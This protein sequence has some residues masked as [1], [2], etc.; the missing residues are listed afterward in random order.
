MKR[1]LP[2]I[3]IHGTDF[4]IDV[5]SLSLKERANE[6]NFIPFGY[7]ADVPGGYEFEYGLD[8]RN[9]HTIWTD[10]ESVRIKIPELVELDPFGMSQRYQVSMEQLKGKTDFEIMVD[11]QAFDLRVNKGVLPT[12]D[13]AGDL[14]YVVLDKDRLIPKDDPQ[15]VGIPMPSFIQYDQVLGEN[16][17]A[18]D[19]KKREIKEL[20]YLKITEIPKN[21]IAV[22]LPYSF[23]LDPVGWNWQ[24]NRDAKTAL[25]TSN[26]SMHFSSPKIP[27]EKTDLPDIIKE[28]LEELRQKKVEKIKSGLTKPLVNKR[29]R[30]RRI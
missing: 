1:E 20:D 24:N 15:S 12:I 10:E 7:M 27:W 30:G 29:N 17:F 18:Y 21:L 16:V 26:L 14:F 2:I 4:F 6:N 23:S 19:P 11:Q 3:N 28:N 13:I 8:S 9:I 5:E 22:R 25:K